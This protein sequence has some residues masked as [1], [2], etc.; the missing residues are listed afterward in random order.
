MY[1]YYSIIKKGS[2]MEVIV[3]E[4]ANV[5]LTLLFIVIALVL[6]NSGSSN[7]EDI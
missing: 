2:Y 7:R 3:Q 4:F 5:G 6:F 1:V